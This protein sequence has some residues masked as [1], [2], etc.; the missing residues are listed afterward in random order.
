[1][2]EGQALVSAGTAKVNQ[3]LELAAQYGAAFAVKILA[4]IAFWVVGRWLI[5]FAVGLLKRAWASRRSTRPCCA[6]WATSSPS[7]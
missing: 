5:G 7:P 6:I 3:L 4:A 2:E 1:M